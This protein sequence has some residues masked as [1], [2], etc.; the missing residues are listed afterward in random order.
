MTLPHKLNLLHYLL[1]PYHLQAVAGADVY[2]LDAHQTTPRSRRPVCSSSLN[3][4]S[5]PNTSSL[6][7]PR[8]GPVQR[9]LP[10]VS[11]RRGTTF[12]IGKDP[13]SGSSTVT[14]FSR[15]S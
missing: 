3:F 14:T 2:Y 10:G 1:D 6:C 9:T 12:C 15:A 13:I 7:W 11:V 8:A 4:S 5:S